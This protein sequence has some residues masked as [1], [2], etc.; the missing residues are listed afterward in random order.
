ML[1]AI[2]G[3]LLGNFLIGILFAPAVARARSVLDR[4]SEIH[5]PFKSIWAD[6]ADAQDRSRQLEEY[7][8]DRL[9]AVEDFNLCFRQYCIAFKSFQRVGT[10]FLV[11]VTVLVGMAVLQ[12]P[13]GGWARATASLA[14]IALVL[15]VALFLQRIIAPSP[16]RLT[17][18]DF[19]A[20][21]FPNLHLNNL[22]EIADIRVDFGREL[23]SRD[24]QLHFKLATKVSFTGYKLLLAVTDA[25]CSRLYY[26]AYGTVDTHSH[27]IHNWRP[28]FP[29]FVLPLGDFSYIEPMRQAGELNLH[30]WLFIPTPHGWITE[31][32][33]CPHYNVTGMNIPHTVGV[34]LESDICH[35]NSLDEGVTFKRSVS[36]GVARWKILE[37]DRSDRLSPRNVVEKYA[38]KVLRTRKLDTELFPGG[39]SLS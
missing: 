26:A 32:P 25:Q 6:L 10:I 21:N 38:S 1:T 31:T 15:F 36:F 30:L 22:F 11:A 33:D 29:R 14:S 35:W 5:L 37:V 20:N 16:S 8:L 2:V 9:K 24:D 19:I 12:I 34:R 27:F 7:T 4:F 18:I 28:E 39:R 17:S 3:I 23:A 13:M